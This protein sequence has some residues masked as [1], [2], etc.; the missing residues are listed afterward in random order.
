MGGDIQDPH[1]AI[2]AAA[3]Y[4]HRSGAPSDYR[5]ALYA[6][7]HATAYVS[8]VL[9]YARLMGRDIRNYFALYNWQVFVLT[10]KGSKRL[11]GP[12]LGQ[13]PG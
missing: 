1:D 5:R 13:S 3:N 8:A 11:T 4:L 12:G 2:L 6:Y 7:N 9:L 10:T